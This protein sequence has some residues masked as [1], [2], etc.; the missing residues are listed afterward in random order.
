MV[1]K[2]Q[3]HIKRLFSLFILFLTNYKLG[4]TTLRLGDLF[5]PRST[6]HTI[7]KVAQMLHLMNATRVNPRGPELDSVIR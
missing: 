6:P 4:I 1:H 5:S 3:T 2:G 7:L